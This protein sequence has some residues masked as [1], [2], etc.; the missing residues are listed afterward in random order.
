[1]KVASNLRWSWDRQCQDLFRWVDP[2]I[3]EET[4]HNTFHLL[5]QVS[6]ERL[7]ELSN[8]SRFTEFLKKVSGDLDSYS[9][10][11]S[12]FQ[13]RES[14]VSKIAYFSPEFGISS[15]LPQY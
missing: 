3:W 15:A 4:D 12:W 1:M 8:D 6:S 9:K 5:E 2:K 10:S 14:S 7:E 13:Q 11:E